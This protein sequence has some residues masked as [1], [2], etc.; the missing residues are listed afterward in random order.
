MHP[1]VGRLSPFIFTPSPPDHP[2]TALP[3]PIGLWLCTDHIHGDAEELHPD[4]GCGQQT[5]QPL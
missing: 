4:G 1:M 3:L 2:K 5:L